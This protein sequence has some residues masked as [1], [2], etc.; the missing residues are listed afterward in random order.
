MRLNKWNFRKWSLIFNIFNKY[1]YYV[2]I[3]SIKPFVTYFVFNINHR[4]SIDKICYVCM[5][6]WYLPTN[7]SQD[8]I[9]W[10]LIFQFILHLF[11]FFPKCFLLSPKKIKL[12]FLS[13]PLCNR[14]TT[15]YSGQKMLSQILFFETMWLSIS[16]KPI[17]KELF[18]NYTQNKVIQL[19]NNAIKN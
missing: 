18:I 4:Y 7:L 9:L 8:Y 16:T 19:L 1:Q 5:C 6:H 2:F 12:I 15:H 14:V 3:F 17:L 11:S 13:H 10:N